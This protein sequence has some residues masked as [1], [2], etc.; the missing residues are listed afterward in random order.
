MITQNDIL[1]KLRELMPTLRNDYAVKEIGIFGAYSDNTSSEDSDIDILV[2]FEKP[3]C[4]F[5]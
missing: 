2:E 1:S 4:N 5:M 3:S